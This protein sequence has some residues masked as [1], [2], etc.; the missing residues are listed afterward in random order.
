MKVK[1][2]EIV[3]K[4]KLFMGLDH[5][6]PEMHERPTIYF[7]RTSDGD[8]PFGGLDSLM[9]HFEWSVMS[10]DVFYGIANVMS[11]VYIPA[12]ARKGFSSV[13]STADT[14]ST[15]SLPPP[16]P[17][18]S[19][20]AAPGAQNLRNELTLN[21][22]KFEQQL[23][24]VVQKSRGDVRLY[25]PNIVITSLEATANDY[26]AV[27]EIEAA[28]EDWTATIAAAVEAEHQ[29]VKAVRTPLGEIDFWRD[30]NASLSALYEQL[31]MGKVQQMIQVLKL[32][33][34]AQ[35]PAFNFHFGELSKLT[36]EA[37]DN[38]KFLA[39]LERHFKHLIDGTFQ[40][41]IESMQSMVNG[42]RMV[43]VISRHYNT[44][45]R[46][47]P[48]METI[49]ET[50]VKRVRDEVKLS[51]VLNMDFRQA[52]RLVS[53]ARDIL[54]SWSD[55]YY[56]M[57]KRIEDSGSDHRWEFD[58]KALFG[59][60][61]YMCEICSNILEILEALDHFKIFLG[62]EL[63]AVTGDSAG[64]DQM[65]K[66]V[67]GLTVPLKV[68]F[69]EKIFDKSYEKPWEALMKRFRVSV[70]E[71]EAMT[72]VFIKDSFR[73]LRSAEG[74]FELVKNFQ[75]IG[76]GGEALPALTA[77]PQEGEV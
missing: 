22:T 32:V 47:A 5:M 75:R 71:I 60:T 19:D 64:I 39:T 65:L 62:P 76:G 15:S 16:P 13:D 72:E 58:R 28:V 6:T 29:K 77:A 54:S 26:T 1:R 12:I 38:V 52:K 67:E 2:T 46:M 37:K 59:R 4:S 9:S 18:S 43:W 30:R 35:I 51:E 14:S 73:K 8:V 56:R 20:V 61:D 34:N 70:A 63:K 36:L 27:S 53:D 69:E 17:T 25:I 10:G 7:V 42:L 45:D 66:R 21:M 31:N 48:L 24:S 74:A 23:R 57:R 44:D 49:A 33:D 55:T 41:I 68:P 3:E 11:Q 50:L 40:N